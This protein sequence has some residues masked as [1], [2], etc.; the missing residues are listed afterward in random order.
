MSIFFIADTH[1]KH[2]KI[3][4]YDKTRGQRFNSLQEHDEYLIEK[5][6]EKVGPQDEVYHLGDF[7]FGHE[8]QV[9]AR[10][11]GKIHLILGNHD[12]RR[13]NSLGRAGFASVQDVLYLKKMNTFLSHYPH[14][15]WPKSYHGC[16]HLFG[17]VHENYHKVP[18]AA[19][20]NLNVGVV[21]L[22]DWTP[23]EFEELQRFF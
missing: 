7:S 14:Y 9:R 5:W 16:I 15:S 3:L 13:K 8:A 2:A 10:L 21:W 18:G 19:G 4:K 1:F 22:P 6:N 23:A 11:N 12:Y 17:H 20:L